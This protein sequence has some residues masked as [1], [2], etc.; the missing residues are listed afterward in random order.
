MPTR[1]QPEEWKFEKTVICFNCNNLATQIARVKNEEADVVCT[2]C[3]A[4]RHYVIRSVIQGTDTAPMIALGGRYE[5]WEFEKDATCLNCNEVATHRVYLDD[6]KINVVCEE[7]GFT[8]IFKFNSL[9]I[10][11]Y[12]V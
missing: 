1:K 9:G 4:L 8:R 11:V 7:C 12:T 6:Y 2:S 10:S 3:N 5:P